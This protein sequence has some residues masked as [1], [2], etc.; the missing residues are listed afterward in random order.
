MV[1]LPAILTIKHDEHLKLYEVD[2]YDLIWYT[3]LMK[4]IWWQSIKDV[5]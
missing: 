4:F 1:Y 5:Q 3:S 2:M